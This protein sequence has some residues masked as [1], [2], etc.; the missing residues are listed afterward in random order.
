[1]ASKNRRNL[2]LGLCLALAST[3]LWLEVYARWTPDFV[4]AMPEP[5]SNTRQLVLLFHGSDGKDNDAIKKLELALRSEMRGQNQEVIRY[6]WSPWSDNRL[7][8][9]INGLYLGQQIGEHLAAYDID[10]LHLIGHSAGA[11]L[12]DAICST[13]RANRASP[14]KIRMTFLDPIGIRG[15]FNFGWGSQ[16]FGRCADFAEAI[17]NTDD[18]VPGTNA[19]LRYAFNIDITGVTHD[20]NGHEWPV[21]YYLDTLNQMSLSMEATHFEMPRGA[22]A[23]DVSAGR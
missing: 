9:S 13:L 5:R 10:E 21:W 20:M 6:I 3:P 2:G 17:I 7:R 14:V 8:A 22:V 12:P 1:M 19:P 23:K 16:N 15:F 11:W 4:T 18:N